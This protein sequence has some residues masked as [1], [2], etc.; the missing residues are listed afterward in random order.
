MAENG[1]YCSGGGLQK[2][3]TLCK[4]FN[5]LRTRR[6]GVCN[7]AGLVGPEKRTAVRNGKVLWHVNTDKS[8]RFAWC[9][10][11]FY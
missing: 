1:S 10:C 7:V 4:R 6:R 11:D 9:I 8:T 5:I 2:R 3:Y